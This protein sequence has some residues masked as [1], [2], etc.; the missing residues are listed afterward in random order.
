M[1]TPYRTDLPSVVAKVVTEFIGRRVER[2]EALVSS[3]LIDSLSV[4]RLIGQ[5]EKALNLKIPTDNL[6]PDDFDSVDIIVET[7]L[8]A[9]LF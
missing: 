1:S 9:V 4:L 6:Q 8:R 7:I 5:L 2:D 3:G